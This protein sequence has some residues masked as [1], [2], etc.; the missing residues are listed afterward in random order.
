MFKSL[1]VA[2]RG[3][4]ACRVIRACKELGITPYTVYSDIDANSPHVALVGPA[5]AF[6]I[7]GN[8]AQQSYL[9][10]DRIV[11]V[12]RENGI[13]AIH[14]GYGFLSENENFARLC[15]EA[16]ITFVG[17]TPEVIHLMGDKLAARVTA[18]AAG[19]PVVPGTFQP[20]R[21]FEEARDEA[22][23]I[24]FPLLVKAVG[25]GGG[26]GIHK[27]ANSDELEQALQAAQTQSGAAFGNSEVYLEKALDNISHI[28]V[29]VLGDRHGN[30][31]HFFERDCSTQRRNQKLIEESPSC[32]M[33]EQSR[34]QICESALKLARYVNYNSAGTVEFLADR[35][36]N[37]YFIEMNTRIQVEHPVTEL[38][39]GHDLVQLQIRVAAGEKL[40]LKQDDIET[41]GAAIEAR[42]LAESPETLLPTVGTIDDYKEPTGEFVRVDSGVTKGTEISTFYDSLMAK[43]ICWGRDREEARA[44]LIAALE[45][46]QISTCSNIELLLSV[47]RSDLFI[48][49]DYSTR[50][51]EQIKEQEHPQI[52]TAEIAAI[53]AALHFDTHKAEYKPPKLL[54]Q[55]N[56][57]TSNW[58]EFGWRKAG[59]LR[60]M[61]SRTGHAT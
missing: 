2:N 31:I 7:G 4:I 28:E 12:A 55:K 34:Q 50:V 24:G 39:T 9:K 48:K 61:R 44:R 14:P 1:L 58:Q 47:L 37:F 21:S 60:L 57:T 15:A 46:Y 17:P 5:N 56:S 23:K 13:E 43:V 11:Q 18:K 42:V 30:H 6:H 52:S 8:P 26:I 22:A 59:L 33:D 3:E 19:V 54:T 41:K 51:L 40:A 53:V 36:G 32:L 10:A 35:D 16:N 29:Q 38:L 49:G 45:D 27:V 25:G 20:A